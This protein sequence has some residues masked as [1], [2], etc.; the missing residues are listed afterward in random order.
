MSS[1]IAIVGP[2]AS[3]KSSLAIQI[4]KRFDGEIVCVD[5]QTI[6][7]GLDIGTAKASK[8]DQLSIPHHMLDIIE[9]YEKYSA[10]AFKRRAE[11]IIADIQKRGKLPILVG[12]TGLYMDAILFD[13]EFNEKAD[14]ELRSA[15][16]AKSVD[17]LQQIIKEQG[18]PL[19]E[20]KQNPRHLIR[21]IESGGQQR[22]NLVLRD[23]AIVIGI[24]PKQELHKRIQDRVEQM[25]ES[26]LANEV[27]DVLK[28]YGPPP[29][30][31]DAIGYA[32]IMKTF[33]SG[34]ETSPQKII[35]DIVI[36]HR[37]YAKRQRAWFKRN[38]HIV[39]FEQSDD[40]VTYIEK[41]L[42]YS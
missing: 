34:Q 8:D 13:F 32:M 6:R 17:E 23:D 36:Q 24:D 26:G 11:K 3:G 29:E 27:Q 35:E 31:W 28:A 30:N 2:T 20:N 5:S 12:G 38:K 9:P 18:L 42:S 10:A 39:W 21:T 7:K 4:A 1:I 33:L 41:Q 22:S 37:Q 16:N 19:P 40:A 25:V 15:L 14:V